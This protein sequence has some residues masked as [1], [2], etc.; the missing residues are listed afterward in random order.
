MAQGYAVNNINAGVNQ[1]ASGGRLTLTSG[2]PVTTSDVTAATSV[3]FTPYKSN[4]LSVWNS[5]QS[6]WIT[7]PFNEITI[8]VP[9]STSQMYDVFAYNNSG[10][11]A[12]ETLAWTNDTTRATSL[13]LQNGI[14]CKNG[15][16]TRRYIGSF[17]TTTVSGQTEDS[18]AKRYVWNYNNRVA[19]SMKVVDTTDTWNYST[20]AYQQ[21]NANAANQLDFIVGLSEDV[22][23]AISTNV[24]FN[25]TSTSRAT[26]SG[27][28]LDSTTVNSA[29][30]SQQAGCTSTQV[31][32]M[33]ANYHAMIAVGRHTLVWL[34]YG[35]GS[36]TQTWRGDNA[37]TMQSGIIGTLWG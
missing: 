26:R 15:D 18:L 7:L 1:L 35:G 21:A 31:G 8:S 13:V 34:E 28:G 4:Y 22:V 5:T 30:L 10:A 2:L 6:V 11:L 33:F 25:S 37:G 3:Y 16:V 27:I 32:V 12:C 20:A 17:R 9:A 19:R 36:D 29:T 14:Y 23:D 24:V